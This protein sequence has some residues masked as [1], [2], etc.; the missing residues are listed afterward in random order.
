MHRT[1]PAHAFGEQVEHLNGREGD[2][3]CELALGDEHKESKAD[4]VD[5]KWHQGPE[6][7]HQKVEEL[8]LRGAT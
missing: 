6:K 1:N 4:S 3:N 8:G 2:G 7:D 5:E